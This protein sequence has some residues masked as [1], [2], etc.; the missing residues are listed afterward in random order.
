[1]ANPIVVAA[2]IPS[3]GVKAREERFAALL[4]KRRSQWQAGSARATA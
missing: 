4:V 2:G 1:M 3:A